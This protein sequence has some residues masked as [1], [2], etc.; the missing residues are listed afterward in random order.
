M[1]DFVRSWIDRSVRP[2][3]LAAETDYGFAD[4]DVLWRAPRFRL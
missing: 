2:V 3:S 1:A 4:R